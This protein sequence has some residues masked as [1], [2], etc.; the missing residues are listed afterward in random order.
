MAQ[1]NAKLKSAKS[2]SSSKTNPKSTSLRKGARTITPK[3]H[4]L[5]QQHK[6]KKK[7]TA[8]VNR[9]IERLMAT[10]ANAVGKLTIMRTAVK[11]ESGAKKDKKK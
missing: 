8:N 5:N 11:P 6:I 3:H 2:A 4:R 7:L 9:N 10:R 1:G